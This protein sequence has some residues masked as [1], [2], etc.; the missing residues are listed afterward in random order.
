MDSFI[1]RL[2]SFNLNKLLLWGLLLFSVISIPLLGYQNWAL[3]NQV[4][5]IESEKSG[6]ISS[7][8][9]AANEEIVWKVEGTDVVTYPSP[10]GKYSFAAVN[11]P[12]ASNENSYTNYYLI[13]HQTHYKGYLTGVPGFNEYRYVFDN[14]KFVRDDYYPSEIGNFLRWIN[15]DTFVLKDG[16]GLYVVELN[17]TNID[18]KITQI[19]ITYEGY[20][21]IDIDPNLNFVLLQNANANSEENSTPE[22]LFYNLKTSEV[23][24]PEIPGRTRIAEYDYYSGRFVFYPLNINDYFSGSHLVRLFNPVTESFSDYEITYNADAQIGRGCGGA[25]L[26]SD[27]E[28]TLEIEDDCTFEFTSLYINSD[29]NIEIQVD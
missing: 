28:G 15:E 27:T 14:L 8:D 29:R 13:D 23:I 25:H 20:G 1:T 18:S 4:N 10:T 19:P 24:D 26:V 17:Q 3:R 2:I 21:I 16:L 22:Y 5:N 7:P 11:V 12:G 9:K 6:D